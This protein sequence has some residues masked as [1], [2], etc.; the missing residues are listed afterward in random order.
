MNF[1]K[2]KYFRLD[3]SS[4]ISDRR[5]MVR[6]FQNRNDVF[7]FLLSTRAGGLGINLTAADT[8]IFYEIDWNPT[9]DQQAM[10][11]THRLGQTKEV[12]VYRL[13][14]KDTIEEKILQRAKQKNAVQELVMKG[15]HVQDDHLLRQEDVVS[16]LIDDTQIAHKLKEISMQAKDRQKKR[17]AKSIKVDKEGDLTLE[18]LDDATATAEAV[19]QDK[20]SKKKKSSHKKHTNTHDNDS[21]D[22]NGEPDVG[23][24]HP[25]S[26][27]TEN[28]QI[29]EPRPKRSKRLMKSI[30]DK[31]LAA[32]AGDE[33]PAENHRAHD[34][35]G[36]EEVQDGTAA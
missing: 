14:C 4:A 20:T 33:E 30:T 8:V 24:D 2:F 28:E 11:R 5:D 32:A 12:T 35:D 10:D 19:D 1:R 6:A 23:G 16:L 22:K 3:G 21:T 17:R 36:T 15:K 34:Y 18:D 9:Q 13:I 27:H 25:G 26:I 29:G 7:V 31:E